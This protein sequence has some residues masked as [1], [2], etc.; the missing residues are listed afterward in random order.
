MTLIFITAVVQR[1]ISMLDGPAVM[2]K[3]YFVRASWKNC[4]PLM[5]MESFLLIQLLQTIVLQV[6]AKRVRVGV[7]GPHYDWMNQSTS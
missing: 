5:T 6:K 4:I 7:K 3:H 1:F 2:R